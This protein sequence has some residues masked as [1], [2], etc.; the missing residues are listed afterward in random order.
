[1]IVNSRRE[2]PVM[3]LAWG[4]L[5]QVPEK[6]I[7]RFRF[8]GRLDPLAGDSDLLGEFVGPLSGG[9]GSN[10]QSQSRTKTKIGS[11][12]LRLVRGIQLG[13]ILVEIAPGD[14]KF[15]AEVR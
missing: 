3:H 6:A 1:M 8:E 4:E 5:I 7:V 13:L 9:N 14:L 11:T 12:F 10:N 15:I 2:R